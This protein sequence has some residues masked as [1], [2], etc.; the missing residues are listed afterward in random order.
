MSENTQRPRAG[1]VRAARLLSRNSECLFPAGRL[2]TARVQAE[3]VHAASCEV[4]QARR[5]AAQR[6][7]RVHGALRSASRQPRGHFQASASA[8]ALGAACAGHAC[9][10]WKRPR[11]ST[12]LW[13][14]RHCSL[15]A[16]QAT[17]QQARVCKA[18]AA[19]N[20]PALYEGSAGL[21]HHRVDSPQRALRAHVA[22]ERQHSRAPRRRRQRQRHRRVMLG[23]GQWRAEAKNGCHGDTRGFCAAEARQTRWPWRIELERRVLEAGSARKRRVV[24]PVRRR[25]VHV[26]LLL[27]LRCVRRPREAASSGA[28]AASH[29]ESCSR[30]RR[31]PEQAHRRRHDGQQHHGRRFAGDMRRERE[32]CVLRLPRQQALDQTCDARPEPRAHGLCMSTP[33][34][35]EPQEVQAERAAAAKVLQSHS[36]LLL[37]ARSAGLTVPAMRLQ[38]LKVRRECLQLRRGAVCA[39]CAGPGARWASILSTLSLLLSGG[40]R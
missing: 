33:Q 1:D 40:R 28:T 36:L 2:S 21:Q 24:H 26:W 29:A 4:L 35:A 14:T 17:C 8:A 11:L 38:L 31:M 7:A 18:A 32:R 5:R 37:H 16:A 3:D 25:D 39:S 10:S 23:A 22:E 34:V 19:S 27:L 12:S 15:L 30:P 20:A 9:S 13:K 6:A